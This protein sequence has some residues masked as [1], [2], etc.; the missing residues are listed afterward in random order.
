MASKYDPVWKKIFEHCNI[1]NYVKEHGYYLLSVDKMKEITG[2]EVRLLN[3]RIKRD[4]TSPPIFTENDLSLLPVSRNKYAIG[5]FDVHHNL[6]YDESI[7]NRVPTNMDSLRGLDTM[8]LGK[9]RTESQMVTY[10]DVSGI[11]DEIAGEPTKRTLQGSPLGSSTFGFKVRDKKYH[12]K[13]HV[14]FVDEVRLSY[15]YKSTSLNQYRTL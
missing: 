10:A 4:K 9:I 11:L 1:L 3:H 14:L 12:D 6:D 8:Y 7:E 5:R 15:Y 2:E 13:E